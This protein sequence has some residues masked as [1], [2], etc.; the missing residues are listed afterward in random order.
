MKWSDIDTPRPPPPGPDEVEDHILDYFT[1]RL[2]DESALVTRDSRVGDLGLH[3][4]R[5]ARFLGFLRERFGF[6]PT[7]GDGFLTR[8]GSVGRIAECVSEALQAEPPAPPAEPP[9]APARR[10][11]VPPAPREPA[12]GRRVD[13]AA[14]EP[15]GTEAAA[16]V[17]REPAA[18]DDGRPGRKRPEEP[19]RPR[20]EVTIL[21][22]SD[23]STGA[24]AG[25]AA[26]PDASAAVREPQ[27]PREP[28]ALK[29]G[30]SRTI[31]DSVA[32]TQLRGRPPSEE[33]WRDGPLY[34][35]AGKT[36]EGAPQFIRRTDGMRCVLIPAAV[37][38]IGCDTA[39]EKEQRPAHKVKIT[40][41]LIDAEPVCCAA[42]A[43]FLNAVGDLPDSVQAEWIG[44][45]DGG[46]GFPL[47]RNWRG[48]WAAEPGTELEPITMVAWYGANAYSLWANRWD[49]RYYRGDG[50]TPE[51]L[52]TRRV[53]ALAPSDYQ[54]CSSLPTEA[55]WEYAARGAQPRRFPW[56]DDPPAADRAAV[57]RGRDGRLSERRSAPTLVN[58]RLGV[59]PFGV[60][61]MAGSLRQWCRDWYAS[62]FYTTAAAGKDD[63]LNRD[64]SGMRA[65]RAG[66]SDGVES[67]H[68]CSHRRGRP[69]QARTR[70]LGFRCVGAADE[71]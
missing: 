30:K 25:A 19:P 52:H 58:I 66:A 63:A 31:V 16:P 43:R 49:W 11:D 47:S 20:E 50:T 45:G 24:P 10:A 70:T 34:E 53:D 2:P 65:E 28:A 48:Q 35:P 46:S 18:R 67:V 41:F 33:D 4:E 59:S 42:F 32:C 62:D 56:G 8:A 13:A 29:S 64:V 40:R 26:S 1:R 6:T 51:P 23:R 44:A 69:P 54:L 55:Q 39:E 7:D 71:V 22:V 38:V 37:A 15:D 17:R 61:H 3:G 9:T 60:H 12:R 57:F 14:R 5:A 36:R 68:T 21:E 27:R